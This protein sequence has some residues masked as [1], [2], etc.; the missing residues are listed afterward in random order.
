MA[1]PDIC[2]LPLYSTWYSFHQN[3]IGNEIEEVLKNARE[4]GFHS[5]IVD[6]GWQMDDASLSYSFCGDWQPAA[7]KI[8]DMKAH[9]QRIHDMGLKYMLWY[10]VPFVGIHSGAFEK[11]RGKEFMRNDNT[12]VLDIRYPEVRQYLIDTYVNAVKDWDLDGFKLDF[13]DSFTQPKAENPDAPEGRDYIS[14]ALATDRLMTDIKTSLQAVKPSIYIEFRQ[15]YTGPLMR[16]YGS[17]FRAMDCAC[18][19]LCNKVRTADIR[20][21]AGNTPAHSDMITWHMED[22]P[23]SVA[24]QF[25]GTM[26]A[27]PQVSVL[28]NDIPDV[29]RKLLSHWLR[30]WAEHRETLLTGFFRAYNPELLYPVLS[31]EDE[32]CFIAASYAG[33]VVL[34]APEGS[35]LKAV[36]VN[37]SGESGLH[38]FFRC[39]ARYRITAI[40]CLG[41]ELWREEAVASCGISHFDVPVSGLIFIEAV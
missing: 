31:A 17:M 4:L 18:D 35:P 24:L 32:C 3:Q 13:I 7:S 28:L 15:N 11:F 12:A 37:G 5:V 10:S 34:P 14:T 20:L 36:Y 2:R 22:T 9:V 29:H 1:V 41:N 8:P 25:I 21:L 33:N 39:E 6:D 16:K 23:E 40:D 26:F 19:S 30:F 27:V 38:V